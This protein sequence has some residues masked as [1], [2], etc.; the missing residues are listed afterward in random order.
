VI[1]DTGHVDLK[2][3]EILRAHLREERQSRAH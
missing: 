3:T 1:L 2:G